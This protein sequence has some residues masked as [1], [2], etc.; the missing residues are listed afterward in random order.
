MIAFQ[1]EKLAATPNFLIKKAVDLDAG[2]LD[3]THLPG[4]LRQQVEKLAA[5]RDLLDNLFY[6]HTKQEQTGLKIR[7]RKQEAFNTY[8]SLA[9]EAQA[10][11]VQRAYMEDV[12][13]FT[14]QSS[15]YDLPQDKLLFLPPFSM[16]RL[17]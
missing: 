10:R 9:G 3:P 4:P 13:P 7:Q 16:T 1:G 8:E 17:S 6:L 5:D 15:L 2:K 14:P 12:S 11:A